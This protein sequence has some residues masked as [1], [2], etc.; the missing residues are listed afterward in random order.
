METMDRF[1]VG[2]SGDFRKPDGSSA[3]PDWDMGPL[4]G[5]DIE[6]FYIPPG[7]VTPESC[8]DADALIL[9]VSPFTADSIP[10]NGRLGLVARFGV[11][12]DSVDV[13]ACT[14]ASVAVANTPTAV[15]RPVAVMAQTFVLALSQKLLAKNRIGHGRPD[16]WSRIADHNGMGLVGRTV[17]ILGFGSTAREFATI[18]RPLDMKVIAHDPYVDRAVAAE[19]GVAL[20]D[21]ETLFRESDFVVVMCL[22]NDGT[23]G[24]VGED[25]LGLMKPTAYLVNVAR[26]PIVDQAALAAA[27]KEGRI[28]GAGLDVLDREPPE[29]GDPIL[30]CDN[31]IITPHAMCWTDQ[32]FKAI[33]AEDVQAVLDFK[34]GRV[35]QCLVNR[36]IVDDPVWQKKLTARA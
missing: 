29:A 23:R 32:L 15:R 2:I 4:S 5:P 28:A 35:P 20:V 7:E 11:G 24:L 12:Y 30:K 6:H 13:D 21:K 19:Y 36:D 3:F 27:L 10:G 31:A 33:G 18:S 26:G 17:G 14:R 8:T 22:L 25:M 16:G 34:D 1:R 9:L